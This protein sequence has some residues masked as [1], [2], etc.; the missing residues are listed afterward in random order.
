MSAG[1][2]SVFTGGKR[3]DNSA[4]FR[5]KVVLPFLHRFP[6]VSRRKRWFF[7]SSPTSSGRFRRLESSSWVTIYQWMDL[8]CFGRHHYRYMIVF[9]ILPEVARSSQHWGRGLLH[10]RHLA[11]VAPPLDAPQY[12]IFMAFLSVSAGSSL[13]LANVWFTYRNSIYA[14][15]NALFSFIILDV[16][17][18]PTLIAHFTSIV[19]RGYIIILFSIVVII[20]SLL[21]SL[22]IYRCV[23]VNMG[24]FSI[25]LKLNVS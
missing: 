13:Y 6:G 9:L 16:E 21:L 11:P 17:I 4:I 10:P 5:F 2:I 8:V 20:S 18:S 15:L 19:V 12:W 3:P 14:S 22:Y 23:R 24:N 1:E 25:L 7:V